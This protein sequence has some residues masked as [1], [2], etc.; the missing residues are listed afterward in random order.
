MSNDFS[1]FDLHPQVLQAVTDLGYE[2]PTP[3]QERA[4][5]A[6]LAGRD[7]LGQAQTGTGKTAAFALPLLHNLDTGARGVQG[8]VVTPTRELALQV[9]KAIYDY[10][11]LRGVRV[12]AVYGGQSYD[13]QIGRLERGVDIVVGTPGR[14]L[15]LI[16]RG[17]LN[18][19][20]VRYLVLDEA[21]EML[22]MG[23][24][25]DIEAILRE[26]PPERQTALFSATLPEPIRQL[27]ERYM[28]N[29]EAIAVNPERITV[30]ETEQRHYL[31]YE[32][33]K[34]AALMRLLEVETVTGALIFTRTK[35]KAAEVADALVARGIQAE[36][37]HGDLTQM[38]R[39]TVLNRFRQGRLTFLVATDVAAR[40]LDI[41]GISHVINFDLPFDGEAYVHRIGRTGRA[42][43]TGVA[44]SLL[45]PREKQ[46]LR[47]IEAYTLQSIP[48]AKLPSVEDVLA[49][50]D[51]LFVRRV[52]TAL[53]QPDNAATAMVQRLCEAGHTPEEL[54]A[55]AIQLVR[56]QEQ[57]RPIEPVNE[58]QP[59]LPAH[60]RS[61]P[62]REGRAQDERYHSQGERPRG[63]HPRES[64]QKHDRE[65]GMVR[66]VLNAGKAQGIR[67]GD[68]VGAIAGEADIPGR[69]IGAIDIQERYT[70]VDVAEKHADKVFKRMKQFR[71][72]QHRLTL[73]YA[74]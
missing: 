12:L 43:R 70:Y 63:A 10:G 3:I 11:R 53:A 66:F 9:S 44:I 4:I 18:L 15:D 30:A 31:V 73:K 72:R 13:R 34:L 40:G 6:L 74:E 28:R 68:I 14:M 48:R 39:E 64:S 57:Y 45:T 22:S 5:P 27:A 37:L 32:E 24:I 17:V 47:R 26:T 1:M 46:G 25:E 62:M 42:G 21:D 71:M 29:P 67:P 61:A 20:T 8:L 65:K 69:D 16:N 52:E 49:Y 41:E 33:D 56:A 19:S 7:V 60:R 38:A 50:R 51:T 59:Y 55:A 23:F 36:A 58:I 35:I 2:I 54:A